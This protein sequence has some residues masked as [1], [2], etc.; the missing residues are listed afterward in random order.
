MGIGSSSKWF[1][2]GQ[3]FV[4]FRP[5]MGEKLESFVFLSINLTNFVI[6]SGKNAKKLMSQNSYTFFLIKNFNVTK[7]IQNF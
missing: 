5:K 7:F 1:F 4:V 2:W 3:I 6:L